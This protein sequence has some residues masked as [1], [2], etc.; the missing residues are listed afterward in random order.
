MAS[1]IM[2]LAVAKQLIDKLSIE[3]KNAFYYGSLAPDLARYGQNNY[4]D[5]HFGG[6]H[7]QLKGIDY[8]RFINKY[9]NEILSNDFAKGYLVH[10]ITDAIWLKKIQQVFIRNHHAIKQEL[11][12]VGYQ[13]MAMY[14]PYLIEKF[15]IRKLEYTEIVTSIRE[16]CTNDFK[17]LISD[18][19]NDILRN[20]YD[21]NALKVYPV[22]AVLE[23]IDESVNESMKLLNSNEISNNVKSSI[24]YYVPIGE[25]L[26]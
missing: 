12:K 11:Y 17:G 4:D 23:F 18:L 10:L 5:S 24:E 16:I 8:V 1:R 25:E 22:E 2:H 6:R 13:D 14:N 3:N 26:S 15:D 21:L 7:Q 9:N 20:T 19:N